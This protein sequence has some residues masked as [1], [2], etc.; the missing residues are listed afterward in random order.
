MFVSKGIDTDVEVTYKEGRKHEKKKLDLMSL[1]DIKG[2]KAIGNKLP[3]QQIVSVD[4]IKQEK[5]AQPQV[6]LNA[7]KSEIQQEIEDE[8]NQLGLFGGKEE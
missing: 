1:I 5:T 6:D 3:V 4:L 7:I 8:E 2:W